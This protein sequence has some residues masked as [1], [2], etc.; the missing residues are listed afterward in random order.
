M[1]SSV[2]WPLVLH[3]HPALA[4]EG[5][6]GEGIMNQEM[7]ILWK[8]E[9]RPATTAAWRCISSIPPLSSRSGGDSHAGRGQMGGGKRI[10][11][12]GAAAPLPGL[13]SPLAGGGGAGAAGRKGSFGGNENVRF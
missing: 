11:S 5:F 8:R 1:E 4:A 3:H 10:P 12:P 2:L 13:G 6:L 9:G 7:G